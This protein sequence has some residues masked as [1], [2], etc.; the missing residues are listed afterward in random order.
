M[1]AGS[2]PCAPGAVV[3]CASVDAASALPLDAAASCCAALAS[4]LVPTAA[5]CAVAPPP[6]V[7]P[8]GSPGCGFA[9]PPLVPPAV[10]EDGAGPPSG[11]ACPGVLPPGPPTTGAPSWPGVPSAQCV[12]SSGTNATATDN[13][14]NDARP[15]R[16]EVGVGCA[17]RELIR[18]PVRLRTRSEGT[19]PSPRDK[20]SAAIFAQPPVPG[21]LHNG[22]MFSAGSRSNCYVW[23]SAR[24]PRAARSH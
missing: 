10:G 12:S 2:A 11:V 8:P 3:P 24:P 17:D 4:T 18:S 14:R 22:Y 9:P 7:P 20:G 5:S 23:R 19:G 21:C 1:T 6:V 13:A 16:D 15:R